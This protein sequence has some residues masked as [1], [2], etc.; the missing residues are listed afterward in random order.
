MS[1]EELLYLI[2]EICKTETTTELSDYWLRRYKKIFENELFELN[3]KTYTNLTEKS[4]ITK[5][6][7]PYGKIVLINHLDS[8]LKIDEI[9]LQSTIEASC[10]FLDSCLDYLNF[11]NK[12]KKLVQSYRKIAIGI[13]DFE[14]YCK[15]INY[16]EVDDI[17]YIGNLISNSSYRS[18]ESLAEEK[19]SCLNWDEIKFNIR[20][21]TFEFWINLDTGEIKNGLEIAQTYNSDKIKESGFQ[22]LPRR[23]SHLL[24]LDNSVEWQ[25]WSDRDDN[26][27]ILNQISSQKV[28]QKNITNFLTKTDNSFLEEE[29]NEDDT[30]STSDL[31]K[32]ITKEKSKN[33]IDENLN[34]FSLKNGSDE[35]KQT[36]IEEKNINI[37]KN[38]E[39]ENRGNKKQLNTLNKGNI[40]T[41]LIKNSETKNNKSFFKNN[42]IEKKVNLPRFGLNQI[43]KQKLQESFKY[44]VI[45]SLPTL[46]NTHK[47][48]VMDQEKNIYW[49]KENLLEEEKML[50][51]L[52]LVNNNLLNQKNNKEY[53]ENN[54]TFEKN[55][56]S[57]INI[58]KTKNTNLINLKK[59]LKLSRMAQLKTIQMMQNSKIKKS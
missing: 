7:T 19:G 40:N 12:S 31:D 33:K 1:K 54:K 46:K 51:I 24:L 34:W 44:V 8:N 15:K 23:N 56:F 28:P 36:F 4:L 22:I 14:D 17:D 27:N 9:L 5:P 26:V 38:E 29:N 6:I 59:P 21:K 37:K 16:Y 47:Y 52:N 48:Q 58:E 25:I 49:V 13:K 32:L 42:E 30:I 53:K 41:W 10:R 55:N 11:D 20:P 18:S 2:K 39:K 50:I 3:D 45:N 43:V 57:V 35:Q